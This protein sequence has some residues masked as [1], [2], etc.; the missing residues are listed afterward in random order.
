MYIYFFFRAARPIVASA[1]GPYH[2]GPGLSVGGHDRGH[3]QPSLGPQ[4]A[5]Y[6]KILTIHICINFN[7]NFNLLSFGEYSC[8][9]L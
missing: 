9:R 7:T 2:C 4:N 8:C 3:C 1:C 5:K 6:I